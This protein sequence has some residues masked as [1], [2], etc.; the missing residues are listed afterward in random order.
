MIKEVVFF[1]IN[2]ISK[3]LKEAFDK[4]ML[5]F[6]HPK[7]EMIGELLHE[8]NEIEAYKSNTKDGAGFYCGLKKNYN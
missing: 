7:N 1:I 3:E 8:Y 4:T 6:F 2:T 5:N